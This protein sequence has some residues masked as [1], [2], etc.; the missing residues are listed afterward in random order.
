MSKKVE[1]IIAENLTELRKAFNL[2]QSDLGEKIGC[3]DKAI[4]RWENGASVPDV[5]SLKAIADF[6]GISLDD[7]VNENAAAKLDVDYE[8]TEKINGIAR[9]CL[10]VIAIVLLAT[11][12]YISIDVIKGVKYWLVFVWEGIPLFLAA[13]RFNKL[14]KNNKW[15]NLLF[16]SLTVWCFLTCIFLQQLISG[17]GL[18]QIF[19]VGAPIEAITVLLTVVR[20]KNYKNFR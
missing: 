10:T 19:L 3:S 8:K 18:W 2:K 17:Y 1:E 14:H 4:S 9:F 11:V 15:F 12:I 7:M 13:Y 6:Y 20:K 16:L 5:A